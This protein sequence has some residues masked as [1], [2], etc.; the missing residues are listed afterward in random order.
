MQGCNTQQ[1]TATY[2]AVSGNCFFFC[3]FFFYKNKNQALVSKD[4]SS[5]LK[6]WHANY[7]WFT[8]RSA[9]DN[10]SIHLRNVLILTNASTHYTKERK[11]GSCLPA[12]QPPWWKPGPSGVQFSYFF[13]ICTD[14]A[15]EL[16]G[17]S[18]LPGCSWHGVVI[19]EVPLAHDV[20]PSPDSSLPSQLFLTGAA[21]ERLPPPSLNVRK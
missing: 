5:V 14:C 1:N 11:L 12:P 10:N 17:S 9:T 19:L 21:N 13:M 6:V 18:V 2:V 20:K 16:W 7:L 8:L 15:E 4:F 3:L